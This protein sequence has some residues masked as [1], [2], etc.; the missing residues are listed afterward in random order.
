MA[1]EAK[2]G[3]FAPLILTLVVLFCFALIA[4]LM[5]QR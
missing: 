2:N 1:A 4:T 3:N 5:N